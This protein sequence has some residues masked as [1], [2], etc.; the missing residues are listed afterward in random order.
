VNERTASLASDPDD[1]AFR[2]ILGEL[3]RGHDPA[4]VESRS[5]AEFPHLAA[6][7][8]Q[9]IARHRLLELATEPEGEEA[10]VPDRLGDFTV[11][12]EIGRGGMGMIYEAIQEPF[13][14]RVALKTIRADYAHHSPDSEER[15][16]REQ[17]VLA[18][19]H[20]THIVPI[21]AAGKE[22][23]LRYYAM[24]YVQGAALSHMVRTARAIESVTPGS[25]LPSLAEMAGSASSDSIP[26]SVASAPT[27][28]TT[29][30]GREREPTVPANGSL[31]HVVLSAKYLRSVAKVVRDAADSLQHA[32][33]AGIFHRDLKPSNIMV[34]A[35][36][37]CWVLDFG[38]AGYHPSHDP[39]TVG[40]GLAPEPA[41]PTSGVRGTPRYMAPE[42]F[43]GH[44]DARTDV[45]GLGVTLYELLTLR[46]AFSDDASDLNVLRQQICTRDPTRIDQLAD[47]VPADVAAICR[48]AMAREPGQRYQSA[49]AMASDLDRWLNGEPVK[50]RPAW[51]L[52]RVAMW[53]RRNKGWAAAILMTLVSLLA[54][55]AG[56]LEIA[57]AARRGEQE[58]AR[59][60]LIL[61]MQRIRLLP[62]VQGW[63]NEA[64]IL[65]QDAA[66]IRRGPELR[67]HA[68][69][70]LA[71]LDARKS[72][73][74]DVAAVA[75][76]F[77]PDPK[78]QRLWI[79][80]KDRAVS[81]W[82][83]PIGRPRPMA[84]LGTGPFAFRPDS[85]PVQLVWCDI[86]PSALVLFEART[87]RLL[88]GFQSPV[89]GPSRIRACAI[90]PD[91][92]HV[93][94]SV[95]TPEGRSAEGKDRVVVWAADT[96]R[97]VL[98][99]VATH[100]TD[101]ALTEGGTMVAA[102]FEE[103]TIAAWTVPDGAAIGPIVAGHNRINCVQFGRDPRRRLADGVKAPPGAGWLLA[104]GDA[105]SDV[106]VWDL[107]NRVLLSRCRGSVYQV[108]SLAFSPDG[109]T[110]ASGGRN[111]AKLW[112]LATGRLLLDLREGNY[113]HALAFSPDG[114][115]L[116]VAWDNPVNATHGVSIWV[117]EDGRGI[118]TLRGPGS[119][120]EKL[121]FSLDGARLAAL[122]QAWQVGVWDRR[123][124]R[125]LRLLD[126]P[127]AHFIDNAG[128]AFSADGRQ[129]AFSAG[130][131]ARLWD[132]ETGAQIGI[133][134]LPE[135]LQDQVH[136]REPGRIL[137]GRCE[138]KD[139]RGSPFGNHPSKD[140]PRVYVIRE[141]SGREAARMLARIEDFSTHIYG[142]ALSAD[143]TSLALEGISIVQGKPV[144][145]VGIYDAATG[146]A[147]WPIASQQKVDN[148]GSVLDFDPT[149]KVLSVNLA[150]SVATLL[151]VTTRRPLGE[152]GPASNVLGPGAERWL[153]RDVAAR[154]RPAGVA[155]HER[156]RNAPLITF[157]EDQPGSSRP[158]FSP[159]GRHIAWGHPNGSVSV[160][161]LVE[162]QSRLEAIGLSW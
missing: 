133:W 99:V 102:G 113:L 156:G 75:L 43:A 82:D 109:M 49:G 152:L 95:V 161:D 26:G 3:D 134:S 13:R 19:L 14:R 78:N 10:A 55:G 2:R 20:H 81:V 136:F 128:M 150:R 27:L 131:E 100:P 45:W 144:R 157:V 149:G 24:E 72:K 71:G 77:D 143:G 29:V 138:T 32:H 33:E 119:H 104:A 112:D 21:F 127:P 59:E 129:F 141:L 135:G 108:F 159:D 47:K 116:A 91:G 51:V 50:A 66:R 114:Q 98:S 8:R 97:V 103:G 15:F 111:E 122:T 64:W 90:S 25:E 89:E 62:H 46:P 123:D 162:V 28:T 110:L 155:L 120:V 151:D 6:R 36:E 60:S 125:L 160:A 22:G 154:D 44:A 130:H 4:D 93:A 137:L 73:T 74:L 17:A 57:Q 9:F 76:A 147:Q 146:R 145:S 83:D 67:S 80:G 117:L 124:G 148:E 30:P 139:G 118:H 41:A 70:A 53:S 79:A 54:L 40:N 92:S 31:P 86:D 153:V 23:P 34:D 61:H 39:T 52:R 5:C 11:V 65:A 142:A 7:I 84:T 140:Y 115:R 85:T 1:E 87:G 56:S 42:Q 48:K 35:L 37:H 16:L 96:G 38:L 58:R 18:R 158:L 126:V 121:V 132:L 105:G 106:T 101:V 68:A 69:A 12:R 88:Q 107:R 94:A 63:S